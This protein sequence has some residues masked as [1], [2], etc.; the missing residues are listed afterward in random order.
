MSKEKKKANKRKLEITKPQKKYIKLQ[1][2]RRLYLY[3]Q[4]IEP[5]SLSLR[6]PLPLHTIKLDNYITLNGKKRK[7]TV[8]LT[9]TSSYSTQQQLLI[10][11]SNDNN[12]YKRKKIKTTMDQLKTYAMTR[13]RRYIEQQLD[14]RH[15][16]VLSP[17][18]MD[19]CINM[20]SSLINSLLEKY[21][22]SKKGRKYQS[23]HKKPATWK[24]ILLSA[25][26]SNIPKAVV[27][28]VYHRMKAIVPEESDDMEAIIT[29][30]FNR[31]EENHIDSYISN[32][33]YNHTTPVEDY[34]MEKVLNLEKN[35]Y[36]NEPEYMNITKLN[37]PDKKRVA[38]AVEIIYSNKK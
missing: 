1:E 9:P 6:W 38:D 35:L 2:L 24:D 19:E 13:L 31:K 30:F 3:C 29:D 5:P 12:N 23:A 7:K 27:H 14:Q 11:E 33:I 32:S 22:Q 17:L 34:I 8:I 37:I 36:K 26:H 10:D 18:A 16:V 4:I 28:K 20:S 25:M 21:A 15:K